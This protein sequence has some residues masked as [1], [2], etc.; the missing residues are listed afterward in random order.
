MWREPRMETGPSRY[1]PA[2]GQFVE[3]RDRLGVINRFQVFL[4][5][6]AADGDYVFDHHL[7]FGFV[8]GCTGLPRSHVSGAL[9]GVGGGGVVPHGALPIRWQSLHWQILSHLQVGQQRRAPSGFGMPNL[10]FISDSGA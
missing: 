3:Q 2:L 8:I 6:V 10:L 5:G 1:C 9:G 7:G 4:D